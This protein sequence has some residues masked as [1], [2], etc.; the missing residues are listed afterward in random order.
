[1]ATHMSEYVQNR[2]Q[3]RSRR[4]IERRTGK[5]EQLAKA[6]GWFS[7][8]LGLAE[9]LAPR[10]VSRVIGIQPHSIMLPLYGLREIAAGVGI[11]TQ[12][13]PAE[14]VLARVAGDACDLASLAAAVPSSQTNHTRLALATAAVAGVT[15]LDLLCAQQLSEERTV[16][17][18]NLPETARGVRVQQS[19]TINRSREDVYQFWRNFANLPRFMRNLESVET[20]GDKR[21]KW[22][23]KG[24]VG[25]QVSWEA[26]TIEDVEN[27]L[28]RW[29]SVQGSQ[30]ATTGT[31][32]FRQ[33]PGK[34][35]TEV[36][37]L[38]TYDP[39]GGQLGAAVANLFGASAE[40]E[41]KQDLRRFKAILE[42]GEVASTCGQPR[43][44]CAM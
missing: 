14:W 12:P 26:E 41:I 31:I 6:L 24:P 10:A 18:H 44:K 11:L 7:I 37:V 3:T 42:T 34:R 2:L 29:K 39:P 1:M 22:T 15:V 21:S 35:G 30:I 38:M 17:A 20:L 16:A 33:A 32:Q 4:S 8:G 19:L 9:V 5:G 27:E 23:A 28:L 43:G 36:R 25:M 40:M 13:K